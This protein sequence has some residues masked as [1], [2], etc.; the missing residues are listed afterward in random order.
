MKKRVFLS[1]SDFDKDK[2]R[3][4]R[5]RL[6]RS[7]YL[8]PI[9]VADRRQALKELA[10][11]VIEGIKDADVVVPL[12]TRRSINTQWINQEIGYARA[13]EKT[14]FPIVEN[15]VL[16]KLKGF[17]NKQLDLPYVFKGNRSDKNKESMEFRKCYKLLVEDLQHAFS[18]QTMDLPMGDTPATFFSGIWR[19]RYSNIRRRGEE[20]FHIRDENQY[21][22]G[23]NHVFDIIDFKVD[24]TDRLVTF[25]K[26]RIGKPTR[27][28]VM[29]HIINDRLLKGTETPDYN[30]VYSRLD[31]PQP[32]LKPMKVMD[33]DAL[34]IPLSQV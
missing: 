33:S 26:I 14:I 34:V 30:V 8:K 10:S 25:K 13:K 2:V 12:L 24:T 9:V 4:I 1:Y 17:V 22:L 31:K 7:P 32:A 23:E 5:R 21:Y 11:K 15:T 27:K 20:E 3:S 16:N 29:L 19:N 18:V 28:V 6:E